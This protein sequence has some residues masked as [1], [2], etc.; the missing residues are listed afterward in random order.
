MEDD[1][2]GRVIQR[3]GG[4]CRYCGKQSQLDAHYIVA[5]QSEEYLSSNDDLISHDDNLITLCEEC[6]ASVLAS[7][8][9]ERLLSGEEEEELKRIPDDLAQPQR[10]LSGK[11]EEELKRV[12]GDLAQPLLSPSYSLPNP[13]KRM[14]LR[15]RQQSLLERQ[16]Q[17]YALG[18]IRLAR[19]QQELID[20]CEHHLQE[21]PVTGAL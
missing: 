13:V 16:D 2:R 15:R 20:L 4:Q 9:G 11:E 19:R 12:L 7:L 18:R 1:Q 17:L 5:P 6:H 10:L 3:D 8:T 14:E 21:F